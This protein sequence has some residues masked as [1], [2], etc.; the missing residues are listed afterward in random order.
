MPRNPFS[1]GGRGL[2]RDAVVVAGFLVVGSCVVVIMWPL[3]FPQTEETT[4]RG[5]GDLRLV[6]SV[7]IG[8]VL[9]WGFFRGW[10]GLTRIVREEAAV[11]RVREQVDRQLD[12]AKTPRVAC[13]EFRNV[14]DII[15]HHPHSRLSS[16]RMFE[17]IVEDA[18]DYVYEGR[19]AVVRPYKEEIERV[20]RLVSDLQ[21]TALRLGILGTFVGLILAIQDLGIGAQLAS[22]QAADATRPFFQLSGNLF[23]ALLIAFSTSVMG[24]IVALVLFFFGLYV[25]QRQGHL[26]MAMDESAGRLMML[27]RRATFRDEGLLASFAQVKS[28]LDNLRGEIYDKMES[29]R[30][31]LVAFGDRVV[32]QTDRID[33][34]IRIFSSYRETWQEWLNELRQQQREVLDALREHQNELAR[35]SRGVLERLGE[36]EKRFLEEVAQTRDLLSTGRLGTDLRDSVALAGRELTLA[37]RAHVDDVGLG[38]QASGRQIE[39]A[40][41]AWSSQLSGDLR[42]VV[43]SNEALARDLGRVSE[44]ICALNKR[45][46]ATDREMMRLLEVRGHL[47]GTLSTVQSAQLGFQDQIQQAVERLNQVP[48]D[49]RFEQRVWSTA[50]GATAPM[51]QG[52]DHVA[53]QL[54]N[55]DKSSRA[56]TEFAERITKLTSDRLF[57]VGYSGVL[58][59]LGLGGVSLLVLVLFGAWRLFRSSFGIS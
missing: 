38:L 36:R 23:A 9:L 43:I 19:E 8:T 44:H 15:E 58:I 13:A 42:G 48:I 29:T 56:I 49:E 18:A 6:L 45:L 30:L 20:T 47:E 11:E 57:Q 51:R 55:L 3:L 35:Q 1:R 14:R 16:D 41:G 28:G 40:F 27:A 37:V 59:A 4:A 25:R 26:F 5:V 17:R 39:H 52:L 7:P 46:D 50:V 33:D 32:A 10:S 12:A 34:G 2:W 54:E 31:A 22:A 21:T 24:L 53:R